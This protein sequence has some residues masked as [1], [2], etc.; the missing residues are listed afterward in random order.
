[1]KK[2]KIIICVYNPETKNVTDQIDRNVPDIFNVYDVCD[3]CEEEQTEC[4][5]CIV[6]ILQ[7]EKYIYKENKK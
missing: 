1:M 6:K 5:N 4:E 3:L 7:N 2:N